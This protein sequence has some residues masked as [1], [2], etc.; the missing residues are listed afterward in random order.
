MIQELHWYIVECDACGR[1][2]EVSTIYDKDDDKFVV[3]MKEANRWRVIKTPE[4]GPRGYRVGWMYKLFCGN[5]NCWLAA[6]MYM[7]SIKDKSVPD[8]EE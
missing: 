6:D 5:P 7:E 1:V 8:R 4:T 3:R 2:K